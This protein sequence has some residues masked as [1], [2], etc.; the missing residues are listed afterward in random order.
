LGEEGGSY[1]IAEMWLAD[2]S[3]VLVKAVVVNAAAAAALK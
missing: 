3:S 2:V 1:L